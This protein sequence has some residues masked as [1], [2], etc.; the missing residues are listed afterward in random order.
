[1]PRPLRAAIAAGNF[2][3]DENGVVRPSAAEV[4]T[5]TLLHSEKLI[6][7]LERIA[8]AGR[9]DTPGDIDRLKESF[10]GGVAAYAQDFGPAAARQ[11]ETFCRRQAHLKAND[12]SFSS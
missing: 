6:E 10:R 9:F 3:R 1:M 8:E 11:L 7:L 2:G 5:L 4:R 12:G